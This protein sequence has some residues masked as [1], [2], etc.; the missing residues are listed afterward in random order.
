MTGYTYGG[1]G[2]ATYGTDSGGSYGTQTTVGP[3][4]RSGFAYGTVNGAQYGGA[5]GGTWSQPFNGWII[6]GKFVSSI[7]EEVRTWTELTLTVRVGQADVEHLQLLDQHAGKLEVIER[8]D[9]SIRTV[10]RSSGAQNTVQVDAP[11]PRE[12][13]RYLGKYLVDEYQQRTVDQQ[14]DRYEVTMRFVASEAKTPQGTYGTDT[15][16]SSEWLFEFEAGSFA[17]KR[18]SAELG[19]Q[20]KDGVEGPSLELTLTNEQ[21][22]ILEESAGRQGGV[23]VHEV[24]DGSNVVE[25]NSP[26]GGNTVTIT[27]PDSAGD[28]ISSGTY[29]VREWETSRRNDDWQTVQVSLAST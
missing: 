28:A 11:T 3:V 6:G 4:Q 13:L 22:Q 19:Q 29:I 14:G 17:T 25:D 21:A 1:A 2:G 18:V 8:P 7:L 23:T 16:S 15:R 26:N 12:S 27:T 9:G 5:D 24:P 20:G 10:D